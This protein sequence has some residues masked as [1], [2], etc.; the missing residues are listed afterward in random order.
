ME[1][2]KGIKRELFSGNE[3]NRAMK[4]CN[5]VG[6]FETHHNDWFYFADTP[7]K[8]TEIKK[9]IKVAVMEQ[10]GK[11]E[12]KEPKKMNTF[13]TKHV[14]T[15]PESTM[16]V[17]GGYIQ[18][19]NSTTIQQLKKRKQIKRK[20]FIMITRSMSK[21]M[22]DNIN[23]VKLITPK[24][25]SNCEKYQKIDLSK[26]KILKEKQK[27]N[28]TH[29]Q[30]HKKIHKKI[31]KHKHKHK[32]KL[33]QEKK[34]KKKQKYREQIESG[35]PN[36]KGTIE[37]KIIKNSQEKKKEGK[38]MVQQKEKNELHK[39]E[40]VQKE[41]VKQFPFQRKEKGEQKSKKELS[42]KKTKGF[43]KLK[44]A[45]TIKKKNNVAIPIEKKK[46]HKKKVIHSKGIEGIKVTQK[47]FDDIQTYVNDIL[48]GNICDTEKCENFKRCKGVFVKENRK[49]STKEKFFIKDIL[50]K[51][52]KKCK[53]TCQ[54]KYMQKGTNSIIGNEKY[55]CDNESVL[56]TYSAKLARR[57]SFADKKEKQNY[58][59]DQTNNN[60]SVVP[61]PKNMECII[62]KKRN[63]NPFEKIPLNM[64]D[65]KELQNER[66]TISNS[67]TAYGNNEENDK[68]YINFLIAQEINFFRYYLKH[69]GI[70][71]KQFIDLNSYINTRGKEINMAMK[72]LQVEYRV[73]KNF[74]CGRYHANRKFIY[75]MAIA[76]YV[77]KLKNLLAA[78]SN[79][80]IT[81]DV[82]SLIDL[83]RK[84]KNNLKL[85]CYIGRIVSNYATCIAYVRFLYDI[86]MSFSKIDRCLCEL[87][88]LKPFK[89]IIPN[90]L[91]TMQIINSSTCN[92]NN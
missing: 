67:I 14:K 42:K 30:I 1:Q 33:K 5:D 22:K 46:I 83:Y 43:L 6:T 69:Y 87:L 13:E 24:K 81:N 44:E 70:I 29:K 52:Q 59:K 23:K 48:Q 74:V 17:N 40:I 72:R 53:T 73:L 71:C 65:K 57:G 27:Q 32:P 78:F 61:I 54:D 45:K 47:H 3:N 10:G 90:L 91:K 86:M 7:L 11:V 89:I 50:K 77:K 18:K 16:I 75:F 92:E 55:T 39:K 41:A 25:Y 64:F 62:L 26:R 82:D 80:N 31:D 21:L 28:Y 2:K 15:E 36:F 20:P 51:R 35:V 85:L 34:Q 8:E 60:V 58:R 19:E 68:K 12:K 79:F 56:N 84:L 37:E 4:N 88:T 49:S 9:S 76:H 66:D 38:S 63:N